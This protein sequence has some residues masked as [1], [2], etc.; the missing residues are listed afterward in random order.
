MVPLTAF[1]EKVPF[2]KKVEVFHQRNNFN[3]FPFFSVFSAA[4]K[5]NN[6]SANVTLPLKDLKQKL[7]PQAI[8][9]YGHIDYTPK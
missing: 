8:S 4:F 6:G 9:L 2:K 5:F 1:K 3:K 7:S